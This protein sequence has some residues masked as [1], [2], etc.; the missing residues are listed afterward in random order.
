QFFYVLA[1]RSSLFIL[2]RDPPECVE[3]EYLG[4]DP[5]SIACTPARLGPYLI[6]AENHAPKSGRWTVL[7]LEADGAKARKVQVVPVSGWTWGTPASTGSVVWSADDRGG[8]AA[9]AVGPPDS[10]APLSPIAQVLAED[11]ISGPAFARARTERELWIASGRTARL[12]LDVERGT[13]TPAW[14]L[15][16]AGP[17][18]APLQVAGRLEV[19]AQQWT[20][21]PGQALWG[22]NPGDGS[23]VWK[24]VLGTPWI[25]NPTPTADREGLMTLATDGRPLVLDRALLQAGGFVDAPLL[26]PGEPGVPLSPLGRLD[27]DGLTVIAPAIG[28]PQILVQEGDKEIRSVV[29]PSPLAALPLFW[30]KEL[31]IP[32]EDGRVYLIDPRSGLVRAEPFVPPFDRDRP[33]HWRT[34]IRLDD[35]TVALADSAGRVRRLTRTSAVTG[36]RL[37]ASD[38][39]DLGSPLA[40]DPASTGDALVLATVDGK[41]RVLAGRDLSP[42]GAYTLDAGRR[43][44]P[45]GDAGFVFVGD[46]DGRLLAFGPDGKKLWTADLA[47]SLPAG[48]PAVKDGAAWFLGLDGSLHRLDLNDG[49]PLERVDLDLL[50]AGGPLTIGSALALPIARGTLRLRP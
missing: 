9:F 3:V 12:D 13:L 10:K 45:V 32:G 26:G 37:I 42:S 14:T 35:E 31:L 15:G 17:A 29:L 21:G 41:I 33:T 8:V 22:V 30:G 28:S 34:P 5:G 11:R 16:V 7:L 40:A 43:F 36:G 50:P 19:L 23:V 47:D 6:V 39:V 2:R 24:T 27:N 44:G 25:T 46:A 48:P 1:D 18:R 49:S 4:H 20:E 38:P